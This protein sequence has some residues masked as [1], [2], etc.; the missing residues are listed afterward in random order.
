MEKNEL[1]EFSKE[2][3]KVFNEKNLS[4]KD[5]ENQKALEQTKKVLEKAVEKKEKPT[6][7]ANVP[8]KKMDWEAKEDK[9]LKIVGWIAFTISFIGII[10]NAF[11]IILC[12]PVWI[13]AN[14]FWIYWAIKKKVW[15]Q[16]WLWIT[17]TLA[18]IFGWYMWFIT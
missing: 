11:K 14:C 15:S 6:K 12:W 9:K 18:N 2:M 4:K 7:I 3:D 1:E 8:L 10:L 5:I 16:V 17:F 13:I